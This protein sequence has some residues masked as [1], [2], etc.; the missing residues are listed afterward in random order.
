MSVTSKTRT[1]RHLALVA[2]VGNVA[3]DAAEVRTGVTSI[4]RH[5]A[6]AA[7]AVADEQIPQ[8]VLDRL[9]ELD[10]DAAAASDV[11]DL[12]AAD[13]AAA[14]K[15]LSDAGWLTRRSGGLRPGSSPTKPAAL[16]PMPGTTTASS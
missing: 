13:V 8:D 16:P 2:T 9:A 1:G 11:Y 14:R 6:V 7:A 5:L 10:A 4:S 12:A 15:E 3:A